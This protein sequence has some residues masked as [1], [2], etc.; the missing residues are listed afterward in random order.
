[1][2]FDHMEPIE[3]VG[4]KGLVVLASASLEYFQAL[5]LRLLLPRKRIH[6]LLVVDHSAF[7]RVGFLDHER[8]ADYVTCGDLRLHGVLGQGGFSD[9][10][11]DQTVDFYNVAVDIFHI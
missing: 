2:V 8:W 4:G 7:G 5:E 11:P 6:P 3:N 10:I 1:M 9:A